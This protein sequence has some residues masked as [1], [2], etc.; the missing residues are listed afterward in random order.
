MVFKPK[1]SPWHMTRWSAQWADNYY[2]HMLEVPD[3]D[4]LMSNVL[5]LHIFIIIK[6]PVW[7]NVGVVVQITS[8][9]AFSPSISYWPEQE[10]EVWKQVH[11]LPYFLLIVCHPKHLLAFSTHFMPKLEGFFPK[12]KQP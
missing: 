3:P 8:S 2:I 7:N 10:K 11:F 6:L 9:T 12:P 5:M 1:S 4:I